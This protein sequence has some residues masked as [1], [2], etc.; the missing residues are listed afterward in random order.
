M[1]SHPGDSSNH[2]IVQP[3]LTE[4]KITNYIARVVVEDFFMNENTNSRYNVGFI[5]KIK[6]S[7][8]EIRTSNVIFF[9]KEWMLTFNG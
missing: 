7:D 5:A 1:I 4:Y 2:L 6:N 8:E 3:E 9:T